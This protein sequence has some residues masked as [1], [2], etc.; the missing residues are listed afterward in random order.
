[1]GFALSNS[2]NCKR[3]PLDLKS[4]FK[5]TEGLFH[6]R[7]MNA[8]PRVL[9]EDLG[10]PHSD[11]SEEPDF[12]RWTKCSRGLVPADLFQV[13]WKQSVYQMRLEIFAKVD[14][15]FECLIRKDSPV[16][17]SIM[18]DQSWFVLRSQPQ[19]GETPTRRMADR[20]GKAGR[21]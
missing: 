3:T 12:Q 11:M 4:E 1:V 16:F 14:T 9:I 19:I 8:L 2:F 17:V 15:R 5:E 7:G 18:C 6:C 21:A 20:R 13:D 10:I